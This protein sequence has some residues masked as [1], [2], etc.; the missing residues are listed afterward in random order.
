M[1]IISILPILSILIVAGCVGQTSQNVGELFLGYAEKSA[2]I[3]NYRIHYETDYRIEGSGQS[4]DLDGEMLI[5][6]QGDDSY[7]FYSFQD[8]TSLRTVESHV[9]KIDS[10]IYSCVWEKG[11]TQKR[12]IETKN[13]PEDLAP[14]PVQERRQIQALLDEGV[15]TLAYEGRKSA[16]GYNC[17]SIVIEYDLDKLKEK[18]PLAAIGSEI[19]F[20]RQSQCYE[21][22]SGL[23]LI[24]TLNMRLLQG[25]GAIESTLA[26]TATEFSRV[27][28]EISLPEDVEIADLGSGVFGNIT[29]FGTNESEE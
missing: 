24:M 18:A 27:N 22:D 14:D 20:M 11:S 21:I 9:Y 8:P 25:D 15:V 26:T 2:S 13:V 28:S 17:D 23:P 1:K 12:C 5:N 3:D 4:L 29:G 7:V 10:N 19:T 16:A 6:E